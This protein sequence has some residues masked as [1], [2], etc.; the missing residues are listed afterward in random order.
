MQ[1][2]KAISYKLRVLKIIFNILLFLC[3]ETHLQYLLCFILLVKTPK[4]MCPQIILL[5]KATTITNKSSQHM[6]VGR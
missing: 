1:F 4:L 6:T 5:V 2:C 3:I